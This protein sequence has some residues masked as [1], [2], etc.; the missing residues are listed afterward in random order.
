[1]FDAGVF[2]H[3]AS[4]ERRKDVSGEAMHGEPVGDDRPARARAEAICHERGSCLATQRGQARAFDLDGWVELCVREER[5]DVFE[6]V[7]DRARGK[8]IGQVPQSVD[9]AKVVVL[10]AVGSGGEQPDERADATS[11]SEEH[12]SEL[13]SPC[14]LVCRLLLEKKN[15]TSI[16]RSGMPIIRSA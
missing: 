7:K 15:T 8:V 10:V 6:R 2:E 3:Q 9:Q 5:V 12:T 16:R 14:N 11:R 1:M 4:V 13:Q